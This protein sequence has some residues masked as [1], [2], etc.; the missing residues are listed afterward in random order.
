MRIVGGE[1]SIL[2]RPDTRQLRFG[3]RPLGLFFIDLVLKLI[4]LILRGSFQF[5]LQGSNLGIQLGD[6][7]FFRLL[8]LLQVL[9]AGIFAEAIRCACQRLIIGSLGCGLG[10]FRIGHIL[11]QGGFIAADLLK[12]GFGGLQ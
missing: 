5:V 2:R 8:L 7:S 6:F 4:L 11:L 9:P 10:I 1:I 12:G 3:R